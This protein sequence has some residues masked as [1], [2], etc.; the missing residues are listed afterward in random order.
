MQRSV[1]NKV[2][3]VNSLDDLQGAPRLSR[4]N[5]EAERPDA[6][7][8]RDPLCDEAPVRAPRKQPA[9]EPRPGSAAL[10]NKSIKGAQ[11]QV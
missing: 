9:A 5:R 2:S 6:A 4:L 8:V 1:A 11:R 10:S 7:S 3:N